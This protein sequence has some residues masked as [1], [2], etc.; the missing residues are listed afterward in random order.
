MNIYHRIHQN[1]T[2]RCSINLKIDI[3]NQKFITTSMKLQ[4][5]TFRCPKVMEN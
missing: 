3:P 5:D 4:K 1:K 2:I